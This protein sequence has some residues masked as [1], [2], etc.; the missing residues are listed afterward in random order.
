MPGRR[1][2]DGRVPEAMRAF[3][4]LA[5]LAGVAALVLVFQLPSIYARLLHVGVAGVS[6]FLAVMLFRI[7]RPGFAAGAVAVAVAFL[8]IFVWPGGLWT[9]L[10]VA[11]ALYL[12]LLAVLFNGPPPEPDPDHLPERFF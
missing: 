8:P 4:P 11:G 3:R 9:A 1:N 10:A 12:F 2:D 7:R 5:I 6:V